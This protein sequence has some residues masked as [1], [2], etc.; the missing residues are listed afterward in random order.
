MAKKVFYDD[1]A[2]RRVLGGAEILYNA[3]RTT[4]GPKGRNVV[5]SKS[6]GAPT[7]THDGVNVAKGVELDDVDDETLG[8]K[9]GSEL[10]KQAANKMNDVAGDGTTTVTILTYHI[11][12][13]ANK[14]I[15]AGHDPMQLRRGLE[16]AA[17]DV[18]SKLGG[19][20]ED[21]A[22]NKS[23]VA[24]VATISAGDSEIGNLIAEVME[25]VGK[26]GVVTVEE[27][28]GLQMES[29]VVEGF[30][31]DR[32]YVSPYMV[33]DT[34]RMEAIYDKP[35]IVITDQKVSSV[36]DFLPMLEK[37]A[38]SGK[39][40]LVL[41]AD[42]VEGEA[43]ATLILN[44]LKGVFNTVAIK[45]P[46]YGDRRK[47]ILE[48]IAILTGGEVISEESGMTFENADVSVVGSARKVIATKDDTTIIEGAG[49]AAAIKARIAQI[50]KQVEAA[51]SE[52]DKENLEK[53]RAA[54]SGK[55]A[56]I[57]VGGATETE[58]EEK[59]FRVD[60]AVASVK[61]A[62][63]EGVVP[64]GGITL[65]NLSQMIS[66]DDNSSQT[67][68]ANILKNTLLEPFKQLM[69]NAGLNAEAKL[70]KVREAK[71]G[72]G[73]DVNH[74]DKLVNVKSSGIVDPTR[75]VKEAIQN[76]VSIAGTA[77]TMGALVNDVPEK[78]P[79]PAM[80]AG[81]MDMGM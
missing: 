65:V 46:A 48:D 11:L 7:V 5:I 13:E 51:T 60:D 58:I 4:M 18:L 12:N 33:T 16:A 44:R 26:D 81:G 53:R 28:Q 74:P 3:V 25:K 39:K 27:G 20:S 35:A 66:S 45:A 57:K 23:R 10:I 71:A 61:S 37:L 55:V 79:P 80:P 15:A 64:G 43:L 73:F 34:T 50:N 75:V 1:D 72:M 21:V 32:G 9:V 59:K 69:V 2:R 77:M 19:L 62:L 24:E 42:E 49:S 29:E 47:E 67:A 68:G 22:G 17:H 56:V 54:L 36:Q 63:A 6:Y 30:T 8:Y 78:T 70:E 76:A 38:Q 31:M 40:D 52:Y 41:I 14:L